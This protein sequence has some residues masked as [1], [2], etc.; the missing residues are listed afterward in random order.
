MTDDVDALI[1]EARSRTYSPS[2]PSLLI[3]A[4]ADALVRLRAERDL[5]K[6]VALRQVQYRKTQV[7]R[8]TRERDEAHATIERAKVEA[9]AEGMRLAWRLVMETR[10]DKMDAA[11]AITFHTPLLEEATE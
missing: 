7:A 3:T 4:L 6:A 1:E 5:L 10:G 2:R 8:L 11:N 9:K